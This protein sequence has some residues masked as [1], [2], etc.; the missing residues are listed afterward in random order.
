VQL[1]RVRAIEGKLGRDR[2]RRPNALHSAEWRLSDMSTPALVTHGFGFS[3]PI[4]FIPTLGMGAFSPPPPP[5]RRAT[6]GAAFLGVTAMSVFVTPR[7]ARLDW[8][9]LISG[10]T[11]YTGA[12]MLLYTNDFTPQE[13]SELVDFTEATFGGYPAG[14]SAVTWDTPYIDGSGLV[15][16]P[17]DNV[18]F[19]CTGSPFEDIFGYY[20]LS[21]TG[22]YLGGARFDDAPRSVPAAGYGIDAS[23]EVII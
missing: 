7:L 3:L 22:D 2:Q 5:P 20:L 1:G 8:A 12:K 11:P 13:D 6:R 18:V 4:S 16:L 23:V 15:H 21:G 14:G 10:S 17:G 9:P 19:L